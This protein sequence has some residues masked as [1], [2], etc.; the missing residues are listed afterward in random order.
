LR[1]EP[2]PGSL[3]LYDGRNDCPTPNRDDAHWQYKKLPH[4]GG[5]RGTPRAAFLR[6][7]YVAGGQASGGGNGAGGGGGGGGG[8]GTARAGTS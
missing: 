2:Q 5:A 8:G 3:C 7:T 4:W 6:S 1:Y